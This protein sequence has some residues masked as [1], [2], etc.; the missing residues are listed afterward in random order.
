MSQVTKQI[1][2]TGHIQ[3]VG[4]RFTAH[5]IAKRHRIHGYVKNLPD[6]SV[7]LLA[8]GADYSITACIRDLQDAYMIMETNIKEIQQNEHFS[9]F[10]ITF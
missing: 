1:V 9:D 4:F 7:E 6:G 2:F 3:G 10:K 5:N 8:Q